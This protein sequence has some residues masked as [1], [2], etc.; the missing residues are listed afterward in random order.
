M[1]KRIEVVA[2]HLAPLSKNDFSSRTSA[3]KP[4]DI[5]IVSAV[6][7]AIGK[8]KKGSFKD[9]H[10]SDLLA[11]VLKA[12]VDRTGIKPAQVGDIVVG[13][14]LAP[15]GFATQARMAM[16]LAG[17]PETV[18]IT[19]V[20]RQCSS[21]L[22][23]FAN[24]AAAIRS[25]LYDIGI[26]AGVESMTKSDMMGAVG[27]LNEKVFENKLAS[28]CLNTMGQTSENVAK[29][30]KIPRKV[31]DELA[32]R[33]HKLATEAIKSGRFKDEIVP[34]TTKFVGDDGKE[35]EI[36]VTQDD[37]P[38]GDTTIEGLSKLKPAFSKDGTT[39]AGNSSQV[40]DG[41]AAV[42]VT[43]RKKAQEL[44]LPILG[45]F[46]SFAVDGVRPDIMGIGPAVAIPHAL[47]LAGLTKDDIDV[48]ELNEA[49]ASQATYC[50]QELKLDLSKVNPNGGAIAL[51]HPLGMTGARQ[52]ATL[53]HHLRKTGG[54]YGVVSMCIG[55]GMGAAGVFE[56]EK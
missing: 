12:T 4:D 53:L 27:D 46:K 35:K 7:T 47:K 34:V 16:F 31:Q 38:R 50:V 48:F 25:G 19:T 8:A 21:G 28:Q 26:A 3:K 22:Q 36:T 14:V 51:G 15:G 2:Q 33:S 9:T 32:V 45:S 41:A 13:N 52:I 54:R 6:R 39:T 24:V 23:A 42:L 29:E 30:F 17:F 40:S 49:F 44:K 10:P 5:V 56:A 1:A 37:G 55:T 20:N 18:P 43:T 11:A